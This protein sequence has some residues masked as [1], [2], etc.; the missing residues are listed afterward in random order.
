M[1]LSKKLSLLFVLTL[2]V[3]LIGM[4]GPTRN[5]V[6]AQTEKLILFESFGWSG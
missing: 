3:S 6:T 2:L 1:K 4:A 5:Q